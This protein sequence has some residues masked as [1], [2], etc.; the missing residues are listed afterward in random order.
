MII[1][2]YDIRL[3][4]IEEHHLELVR[5]WRNADKISRV[6]E[7]RQYITQNMQ[8]QW[9]Q[10][11]EL[12]RDFYFIIEYKERYI[13]LI[14]LAKIN[15]LSSTGQSGL[16]IWNDHYVGSPI[17][18]MASI[19][20]LDTFF[21]FFSLQKI[22]AKVKRDN[23]TAISYNIGLGFQEMSDAENKTFLIMQLTKERYENAAIT[24]KELLGDTSDSL[25]QLL[26]PSSL[27]NQLRQAGIATSKSYPAGKVTV[28]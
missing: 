27:Y 18:V 2:R 7:F 19:N 10:S 20:L 8:W 14:H 13:G 24:I 11:L 3:I 21:Y 22:Q 16:F 25:P 12:L 17:P 5:Y 15:W 26:I 1:I 9:F 28:V 6:M 4:R 23:S